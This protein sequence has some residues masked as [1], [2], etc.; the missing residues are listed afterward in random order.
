MT[1]VS[2]EITTEKNQP[3]EISSFFGEF[4]EEIFD[5]LFEEAKNEICFVKFENEK[6][7]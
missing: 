6:N 5:R 2:A 4:S 7:D 1:T 3:N